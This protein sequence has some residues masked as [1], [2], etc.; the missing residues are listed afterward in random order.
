MKR[1]T[2]ILI[3]GGFLIC[4]VMFNARTGFIGSWHKAIVS[5][6]I[7]RKLTQLEHCAPSRKKLESTVLRNMRAVEITKV[8]E[9]DFCRTEI[10][11]YRKQ[12]PELRRI[13]YY[14][15]DVF[16]FDVLYDKENRMVRY[17]HCF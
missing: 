14:K 13:R 5:G 12:F 8:D 1:T 11:V 17:F 10:E 3:S 6:L 2:K 7:E 15:D 4:L 16:Y 9:C